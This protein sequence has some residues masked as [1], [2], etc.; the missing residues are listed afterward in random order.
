[1]PNIAQSPV[2][3][4]RKV[5]PLPLWLRAP[6][7]HPNTPAAV[8]EVI[9]VPNSQLTPPTTG[10]GVGVYGSQPSLTINDPLGAN[11]PQLISVTN[12]TVDWTL[13]PNKYGDIT[14]G[15]PVANVYGT[16][17]N[18]FS[19]M[20]HDTGVY[21]GRRACTMIGLGDSHWPDNRLVRFTYDCDRP[22][23][24]V[25]VHGTSYLNWK[26][27][28]PTPDLNAGNQVLGIGWTLPSVGGGFQWYITY[29][30]AD[31]SYYQWTGT[32]PT[33][34]VWQKMPT[35]N[36]GDPL[37]A[38]GPVNSHLH[39]RGSG[40]DMASGWKLYISQGG[41]WVEQATTGGNTADLERIDPVARVEDYRWS[42]HYDGSP[43]G[44]H[45]YT[46]FNC[47]EKEQLFVRRGS[48]TAYPIDAGVADDM[49]AGN[50]V[51]KKWISMA[52][53]DLPDA[54]MFPRQRDIGLR[55]GLQPTSWTVKHPVTED[56][57]LVNDFRLVV[58]RRLPKPARYEIWFQDP[59]GATLGGGPFAICQPISGGP[60]NGAEY[61]L[62]HR[63]G[64]WW[65]ILINGTDKTR[66]NITTVT[67]H[68]E[69]INTVDTHIDGMLWIPDLQKSFYWYREFTQGAVPQQPL[70]T[71]E[72]TSP[73]TIDVQPVP[74]V[75][76]IQFTRYNPGE[77]QMSNW[78]YSPRLK[79]VI[80]RIND[81]D[82]TGAYC[83]SMQF[84]RTG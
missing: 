3:T 30:M 8:F 24:E 29:N 64:A 74:V 48:T 42:R 22:Y 36:V 35:I 13:F 66:H 55:E 6:A 65:W 2:F 73:T 18:S 5:A 72:L 54:P 49:C 46:S 81:L 79:G 84:M 41:S 63:T 4:I 28:F 33:N 60:T 26:T 11:Y 45:S 43:R 37:P 67:G 76:G 58:L 15:Y 51:T 62:G 17:Y 32:T 39:Q 77:G 25:A 19:G 12:Q 52:D 34:G 71:V 47:W 70:V 57:W 61:A 82:G 31:H 38:V 1:M 68:P 21:S 27:G 75:N 20:A 7:E 53:G 44:G 16:G 23:W 14:V 83:V 80:Y 59:A 56:L 69:L 50:L 10:I 78:H 9:G 40:R